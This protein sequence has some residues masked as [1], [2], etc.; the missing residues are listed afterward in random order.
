LSALLKK[1]KKKGGHLHVL[2]LYLD[3]NCIVS[4]ASWS[5]TSSV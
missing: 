4:Y 3:L 5:S 1:Y 2:L